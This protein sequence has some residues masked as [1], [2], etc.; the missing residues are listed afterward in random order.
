M[1][2]WNIYLCVSIIFGVIVVYII[3]GMYDY[4][5]CKKDNKV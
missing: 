3:V 1:L 2:E 5:N 4:V